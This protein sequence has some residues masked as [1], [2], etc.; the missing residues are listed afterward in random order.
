MPASARRRVWFDGA[1]AAV[2]V[3]QRD[4]LAPGDAIAG[5]AIVEQYDTCTYLAPRWSMAVRNDLLVLDRQASA[6]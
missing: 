5:P 6:S 1:F 3:F 4:R 2:P